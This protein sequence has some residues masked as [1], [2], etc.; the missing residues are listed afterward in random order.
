MQA[1]G[2]GLFLVENLW[3][4]NLSA[5]SFIVQAG[6][7]VAVRGPSGSGKS[8][9][10]RG[11]A[12]LDPCSGRVVLDGVAR[13]TM[14]APVWRRRVAYVPA[15]PGWWTDRVID[16]MAELETAGALAARLGFP[17][18]WTAWP[19]ARLS[20]GEAQRLGL[21]RAMSR[22]PSVLLLDEPTSGLDEESRAAVESVVKEYVEAGRCALWVSHDDDQVTRIC[23]RS[24]VLVDGTVVE[25]AVGP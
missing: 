8:M 10:L 23:A 3:T 25:R 15:T 11:L 2:G 17:G 1:Y 20:T 22:E 9:L 4:A 19:V 6:E 14:P 12:D 24:L 21:V 18:D 5:A 13:E 7:C 16:H